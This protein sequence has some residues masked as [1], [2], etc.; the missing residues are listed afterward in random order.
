MSPMHCVYTSFI[1]NTFMNSISHVLSNKSQ[2]MSLGSIGRDVYTILVENECRN[3]KMTWGARY[4][5]KHYSRCVY[6]GVFR[7]RLTFELVD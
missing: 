1:V 4:W 3:L 7:W 6:E 2:T 5:V